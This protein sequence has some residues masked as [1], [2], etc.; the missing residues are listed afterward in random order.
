MYALEFETD[1]IGNTIQIP[2]HLIKRVAAH[3]HAKII[4]LLSEEIDVVHE[5][6]LKN[7]ILEI[8]KNCS[9]LPLLDN[10]TANDILGYDNDGM[11]T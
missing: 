7:E 3:K 6:N 4:L 8:G 9:S 5:N 2:N 10:R 1:I 11:P